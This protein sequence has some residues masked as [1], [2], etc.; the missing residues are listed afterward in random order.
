MPRFYIYH[1]K[2]WIPLAIIIW[3]I[4]KLLSILF[5]LSDKLS[6]T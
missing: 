5:S 2:R 6:E 1:P 4:F 3:L